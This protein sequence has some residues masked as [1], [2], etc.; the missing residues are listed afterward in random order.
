MYLSVARESVLIIVI[1]IIDEAAAISDTPLILFR[2]PAMFVVVVDVVCVWAMRLSCQTSGSIGYL[3]RSAIRL[4]AGSVSV[5]CVMS[6]CGDLIYV[7]TSR[8]VSLY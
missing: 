3:S 2:Q 8:P 1:V 6:W 5:H 4:P 7:L